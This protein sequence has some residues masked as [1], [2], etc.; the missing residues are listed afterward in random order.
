[1][2]SPISPTFKSLEG[3]EELYGSSSLERALHEES[4]VDPIITCESLECLESFDEV[5]R[6]ESVPA[7]TS[8]ET[9]EN[10]NS[11]K[12]AIDH[13]IYK[14]LREFEAVQRPSTDY[15]ET[16]QRD[17]NAEMRA[18]LIDEL[19]KATEKKRLP[20]P[21]ETICLTVN[22]IDRYLSGISINRQ[23]LQLLG[24]AC[25]LI[26]YKLESV[27]T[28]V[29]KVI[30]F[31]NITGKT[32][33][34]AEI[35]QMESA[36]L[37]YLNFE[38]SV[39]TAY[40]FLTQ[41]ICAAEMSN[42]DHPLQFECLSSYILHLSLVEYTM[43]QYASPLIAASAAFLARFILSPLDKPWDSKWRNYTLYQPFDLVECVTTLHRLYR[44][45]G[46]AYPA[47]TR[48]KYSQFKYFFVSTRDCHASIPDEFFQD[49]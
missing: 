44:N 27:K 6:G 43:L 12:I 29:P 22:Y 23:Q 18:S 49:V 45:G 26:A 28:A 25:M 8:T 11:G 13:D 38:M 15:M 48:D 4:F 42:Q 24:L 7:I 9:N 3:L 46:A 39:P 37:N 2:E 33:H 5:M 35:V 47:A 30:I 10:D 16:V 17:I 21:P 31:C 36:V 34:K 1:M 19:V 32:Y 14:Y 20:L 40:Y 41:F